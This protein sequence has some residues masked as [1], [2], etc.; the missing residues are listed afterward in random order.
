MWSR[1]RRQTSFGVYITWKII[2][3]MDGIRP[4]MLKIHELMARVGD[5]EVKEVILATNPTIEGDT[6]RDVCL[7]V[8]P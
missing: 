8:V 3:P 6:T 1:W 7:P 2:C 5:G 4:D